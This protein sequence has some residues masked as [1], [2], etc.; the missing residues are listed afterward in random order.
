M[1]D[2]VTTMLATSFFNWVTLWVQVNVLKFPVLVGIKKNM[3]TKP[4]GEQASHYATSA[5]MVYLTSHA[6]WV[7]VWILSTC[8]ED[9][10]YSDNAIQ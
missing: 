9:P 1:G 3:T 8:T 2:V 6:M 10:T 4:V 5:A 7:S